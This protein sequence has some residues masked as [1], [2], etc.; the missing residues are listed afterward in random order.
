ME[1]IKCDEPSSIWATFGVWVDEQPKGRWIGSCAT[2]E[3]ARLVAAQ[4]AK[5]DI[6]HNPTGRRVA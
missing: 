6:I 4:Y 2:L 1:K 5:T 3:K